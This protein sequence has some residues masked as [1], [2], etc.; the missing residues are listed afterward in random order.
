M[1]RSINSL[2]ACGTPFTDY[3][4]YIGIFGCLTDNFSLMFGNVPEK[5]RVDDEK[6]YCWKYGVDPER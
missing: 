4:L 6:S 5:C 1:N 2:F 3:M